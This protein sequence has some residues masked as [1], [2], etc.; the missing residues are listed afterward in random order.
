MDR[1]RRFA[2]GDASA[3]D[4]TGTAV[5]RPRRIAF[6]FPGQ[7]SQWLGMTREL[8]VREPAFR[9]ALE[10]CER[11]M[12]RSV[13]WSLEAML[14]AAEGSGAEWL[15]DIAI[16]QPALAAVEIALAAMWRSW[17]IEP[18][19]V[20]GHSMG[21]IAAAQ[22]A[23][24][25]SLDDAMAIVVQR[26]ALMKT[27]RGR[28]GMALVELAPADAE[29]R[30]SAYG[31]ALSVA[32][33]NAPR[34]TVVAGDAVALDALLAELDGEGIFC[35]RVKVD[36]ASHGPQMDPLVDPLADAVQGVTGRPADIAIYSTV[37]GSAIEG[38]EMGAAYW[39]R[40]LRAT[41]RFAPVVAQMIADGIDAFIELSPHPILVP[42]IE[43]TV[44]RAGADVMVLGSLRREEPEQRALLGA[45]GAL[46]A[47]GHPA[48]F[49]RLYPDGYR[50]LDLPLYPWRHESYWAAEAELARGTATPR[51]AASRPDQASLGWLYR[52]EWRPEPV[53]APR[54]GAGAAGERWLVLAPDAREGES[55]T[56]A[57]RAQGAQ[58]EA[59]ALDQLEELL[60]TH[61]AE[62]AGLRVVLLAPESAEAPFLP[63][64]A[65]QA[66]LRARACPR[67]W[68][69]TRG[70]QA[71]DPARRAPVSVEQAALWGAARVVAEEHPELWG[72]LVDVDAAPAPEEIAP[73]L[74]LHLVG[75]GHEDQ[76]AIR[77]GTR[78]ALRL[79]R[80][81]LDREG[82]PPR[83]R[84]DGAYLITG[85]LGDIG[86]RVARYLADAG[87]RRLVLL[88]RSRLPARAQWSDGG[89]E[90]RTAG[91]IAAIRELEERGVAVHVAS[92]DVTDGEALAA[93]VDRY[94]RELWPPI[95]GVIH[96]AAT[97]RHRLSSVMEREAFDGVMRTKLLGAQLLDRLFPDVDVFVLFS[98]LAAVLPQAGEAN[99]AA[100]NAALEALASNRRGRGKAALTIGWGIWEGTGLVKGEVGGR[101]LAEMARQ[102]IGTMQPERAIELFAALCAAEEPAAVASPIDWAAF[103]AARGSRDW[104]L[105]RDLLGDGRSGMVD[106]VDLRTRLAGA[107]PAERQ[108]LLE[109]VVL[110]TASRVLKI[111][112]SRLDKRRALGT[113]GLNSLM[114][115]ELRNRLETALGR[116]LSATLAWNYPTVEAMS[117]FLAGGDGVPAGA[118]ASPPAGAAADVLDGDVVG[119]LQEVAGLS[120]QDALRALR[121]TRGRR[122]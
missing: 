13:D 88:G 84:T 64:R 68:F 47:A 58:V 109:G 101:T 93:F 73:A 53:A 40:N 63:V 70:S 66:A 25:L 1:L 5:S 54:A 80:L 79:V 18:A 56:G 87:V 118:P 61:G 55:L 14:A 60:E 74:A 12:R 92:V 17:G 111:P 83:W 113:L 78:S 90:P 22:V 91:R 57:L 24:A 112:A 26:S 28:G 94:Q 34:S 33:L 27:T 21:E 16:V 31:G 32:A 97:L 35:R 39:A 65:V 49:R 43:E 59:G 121:A 81:R 85:G 100:A 15:E 86:L 115:M 103:R 6:V 44:Q 116:S 95:R 119:A 98:S 69:V 30:I 107:A 72:G 46:F 52:L 3:A 48:D 96:A 38:G 11:A 76:V 105:L 99:Y 62:S 37:T 42:A 75:G 8:S 4:G 19:A 50:R 20:V 10:A 2:A 29:A 45:L 89:H 67:L 77:G 102:G 108:R 120:D 7:G 104:P 106:N 82:A 122:A 110:D 114:A 117:A 71:V 41:V 23:G 36:V 9:A 51:A